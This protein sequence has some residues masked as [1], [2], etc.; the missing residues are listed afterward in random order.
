MYARGRLPN[1]EEA[2]R[3]L[4]L[5]LNRFGKE[6]IMPV[7]GWCMAKARFAVLFGGCFTRAM[8]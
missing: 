6:W 1:D 5:V 2:R 7:R 3:L 4:L 8:V